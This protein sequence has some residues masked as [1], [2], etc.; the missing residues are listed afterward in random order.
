MEINKGHIFTQF[1]GISRRQVDVNI[2]KSGL[3]R[4]ACKYLTFPCTD[5]IHLVVSHIDPEMM[6]LSNMSGTQLSNFR[7][8]NYQ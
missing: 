8:K 4:V 6:T 3:Y 5:I 7:T 2:H 1:Q